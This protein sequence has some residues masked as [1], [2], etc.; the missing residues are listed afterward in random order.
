[1]KKLFYDLKIRFRNYF[2]SPVIKLPRDEI[3][4]EQL[5]RKLNEYYLRYKKINNLSEPPK[6]YAEALDAVDAMHKIAVGCLKKEKF[7]LGI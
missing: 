4:V 2:K 5:R 6:G 7:E 1:M 3:R